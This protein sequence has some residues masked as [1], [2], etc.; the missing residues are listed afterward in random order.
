M[1]AI[2][3]GNITDDIILMTEKD[4]V[5]CRDFCDDRFWF[6]QGRVTLPEEMMRMVVSSRDSP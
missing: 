4:A 3:F 2:G 6:V 1:I 5:K